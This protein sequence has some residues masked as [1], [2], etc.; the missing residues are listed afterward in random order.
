MDI[1]EL[2]EKYAK[3]IYGF[4]Y[5]K[6]HNYHDSQDLSGNIVLTLCEIDWSSKQIS[7][8]DGYIYKICQYSW[9]NFV[10][11]NK[12]YWEGCGYMDEAYSKPDDSD[13]L[14]NMINTELYK[15]LRQ[16]IMYLSE[17]KRKCTIM[18][19]Y[20]GLTL[21]D[22]SKKLQIPLSTVKWYLG[23]SKKLLKEKIEMK[24]TIFTPKKLKIYYSG[25]SATHHL[26][27]L[28][29]D[30]LMHN[31]CI[32]CED[33]A[34]TVEQIAS[35]LC[36]SAAFIENKLETLVWMNYLERIGNKYRTTFII[37]DEKYILNEKKFL[38]EKLPSIA[39]IIYTTVK[40]YLPE[41]KSIG[42]N[43][44]DLDENFLMWTF[45]TRIAHDF[46]CQSEIQCNYPAPKRG[47]GSEHWIDASYD[48]EDIDFKNVD[49]ELQE[50]V[51]NSGGCA[52]K[53]Q[54]SSDIIMQQFD[55]FIVGDN[56]NI[57]IS[58]QDPAVLNFIKRVNTIAKD[59]IE[60][61]EY[62]KDLISKYIQ[63]GIVSVNDGKIKINMPYF[64]K[65]EYERFL[66]ITNNKIIPEIKREYGKDI[67]NEYAKFINKILPSHTSKGEKE[68]EI[69]NFYQPNAYSYLLY[70]QGKLKS[71][72]ENEKKAV[73][74]MFWEI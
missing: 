14:Q 57:S 24:E 65:D 34:L 40:K 2:V 36:I 16:E 51:K 9:S 29:N 71:L 33:E 35:T 60:P 19:Y 37:K 4:A 10:R 44:N 70:K 47:D 73:C 67:T 72:S 23:E 5:S 52:G 61:S 30:L 6:T 8:M 15:K 68:H 28:R 20:D 31:I 49:P 1:N 45:V 39:N 12:P 32:V 42:F 50:F 3:K 64:K 59:G 38:Y 69:S 43:G 11:T 46:E 21:N 55:P 41:I 53:H 48:I 63:C 22:I 58:I 13:A 27:G 74:T 18:H 62:E 54:S 26:Q 17:N 66:E 7:D 56:H 25:K